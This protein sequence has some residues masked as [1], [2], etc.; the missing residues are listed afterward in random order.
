MFFKRNIFL[1]FFVIVSSGVFFA[2]PVFAMEKINSFD[3]TIAMR[4]NSE[5]KVTEHIKY[6]F[7]KEERHGIFREIPTRYQVRGGN[8]RLRLN[9]ISV[10][11]E[12]GI[13]YR[14]KVSSSGNNKKIKIGDAGTLISGKKTYII[15][16]TVG[17][18]INY[19]DTHDELYWNVTGNEWPVVMD[20]ASATIELPSATDSNLLRLD[21]FAG[22]YGS[23]TRCASRGTFIPPEGDIKKISFSQTVLDS[24]EGMTIVVGIPKGTLEEPSFLEN[25]LMTVRDNWSMGVPFVVCGVLLYLWYIKGR[26][27][28][29]RGTIVV[30]FDA[31]D[32]LT[33]AEV[34][35]ILDEYAETKDISAQIIDLAVRGYLKISRIEEKGILWNS[36][37]YLLEKLKSEETLGNEF[38]KKLMKNLFSGNL[39]KISRIGTESE[40]EKMMI[41]DG[42]AT[43]FNRL[44]DLKETFP[45]SVKG[46]MDKIY[47][48]VVYKGYFPKSPQSIRT[49]YITIG[50]LIIVGNFIFS[51]TIFGELSG[52]S[53]IISGAFIVIFGLIMP[54]KTRRGV[55]AREHILGLKEYLKVAE[56]D[57]I[58]FHNAPEKNPNHF[59]KLLPYAMVLGVENEWARQFEGVYKKNPDWYYDPH[60]SSFN[61]LTLTHGLGD[62]SSMA[63]STFSYQ[64]GASGGGSGFGGGGFS[65]G[66]FGGGGGGSW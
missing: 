6:D 12:R 3:A 7:G 42:I 21:C 60:S 16:Y 1:L 65:G 37:D 45:K 5:I 11:D 52:W 40:I 39:E 22:A 48:S 36:T 49:T 43:S 51:R 64:K 18:A 58:K 44:S 14:F 4:S 38:E 28:E 19:F 41:K 10:T 33:P 62:F 61:A 66:G 34:G 59:E 25:F 27:P 20:S 15:S 24:R 47:E 35:T 54:A 29:G 31:P 46:I 30:Q 55:L 53:F 32:N 57:R 26:D 56:K 63:N 9:N 50:A 23:T 8:Y 17:R 13:P 2:S